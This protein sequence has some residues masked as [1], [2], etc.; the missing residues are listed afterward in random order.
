VKE[1]FVA[2]G[3]DDKKV[4]TMIVEV[5]CERKARCLEQQNQGVQTMKSERGETSDV[6][7]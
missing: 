4:A 6:K 2:G 1:V 5:V 7:G 3:S